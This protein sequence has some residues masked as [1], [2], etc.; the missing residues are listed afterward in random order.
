MSG[1]ENLCSKAEWLVNQGGFGEFVRLHHTFVYALPASLASEHAA[2]LMCAGASV[3]PC[4]KLNGVRSGQRVGVVG[5]GGLG[6]LALQFAR[7]WGVHVTALS[8]TPDKD[9][10]AR[11][12]GAHDFVCTADRAALLKSHTHHF[13][14]LLVTVSQTLDWST[15]LALV[16]NGGTICC[17][18]IP[19]LSVTLPSS[20]DFITRELHFVGSG[21]CSRTN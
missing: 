17:V 11:R 2:P 5:I 18:G 15:Y 8:S 19:G 14:F 9:A 13:D 1:R 6:H 12:F 16:R 10:E 20:F 7:A 3:Y 4:F 21:G